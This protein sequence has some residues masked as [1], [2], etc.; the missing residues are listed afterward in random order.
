MANLIKTDFLADYLLP[1]QGASQSDVSARMNEI[2]KKDPDEQHAVMS[3]YSMK[4]SAEVQDVLLKA[5]GRVFHK[6]NLVAVMMPGTQEIED[7]LL[8]M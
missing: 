8:S 2:L 3:I 6:N 7:Q 1:R 5:F 4:G